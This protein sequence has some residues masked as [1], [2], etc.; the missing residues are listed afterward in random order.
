MG[1]LGIQALRFLLQPR[2]VMT[3]IKTVMKLCKIAHRISGHQGR[4]F[5]SLK[6]SLGFQSYFQS[7]NTGRWNSVNGLYESSILNI[8]HI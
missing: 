7:N 5:I 1:F 8:G 4:I 6:Q 3:N 2:R